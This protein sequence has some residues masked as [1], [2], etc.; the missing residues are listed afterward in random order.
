MMERIREVANHHVLAPQLFFGEGAE[1]G[2]LSSREGFMAVVM[3][4]YDTG[5][6]PEGI[7]QLNLVD[8]IPDSDDYYML[9]TVPGPAWFA[10]MQIDLRDSIPSYA[11]LES[12]GVDFASL[13]EIGI[14]FE[15]LIA[16][17]MAHLGLLA[18]AEPEQVLGGGQGSQRRPEL[19]FHNYQSE[20]GGPVAQESQQDMSLA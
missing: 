1:R 15:G 18:D 19:L 12:L 14:S 10:A 11:L 3:R 5:V 4:R 9:E 6:W 2:V 20:E 13:E 17:N 8:S 7:G 16:M